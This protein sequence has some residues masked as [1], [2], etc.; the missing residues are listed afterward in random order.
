MALWLAVCGLVLLAFVSWLPEELR[1]KASNSQRRDFFFRFLWS[2]ALL[3]SGAV[4]WIGGMVLSTLATLFGVANLKRPTL[5]GV[6]AIALGLWGLSLGIG[7]IFV[8]RGF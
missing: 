3:A 6:T 4:S 1:E 7:V 2:L 8:V 5:E